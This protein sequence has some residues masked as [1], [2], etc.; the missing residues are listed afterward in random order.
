MSRIERPY[1]RDIVKEKNRFIEQIA[2]HYEGEGTIPEVMQNQHRLNM[3]E[4]GTVYNTMAIKLFALDN[5]RNISKSIKAFYETKQSWFDKW[6]LATLAEWLLTETGTAAKQTSLTTVDDIKTALILA[7]REGVT[8]NRQIAEKILKVKGF[9]AFRAAAIARTE[10]H[11]AAMYSN[12]SSAQRLSLDTGVDL[13]KKWI[14]VQDSRTRESHSFMASAEPIV[15]DA[16]FAV[17]NDRMDRPGD[18]RG[19]AK[20]VINCRCTLGYVPID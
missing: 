5:Q 17:G 9:S 18:P 2:K 15:M 4:I 16:L 14:P 8:S 3:Q 1:M 10:T 11:N 6:L 13:V 19:S 20:N 12:K 7:T